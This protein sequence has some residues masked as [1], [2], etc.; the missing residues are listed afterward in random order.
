[1]SLHGGDR[2]TVGRRSRRNM[3][4]IA[5]VTTGL[6]VLGLFLL[7]ALL[8]SLGVGEVK[9]TGFD[10][11]SY[12]SGPSFVSAMGNAIGFRPTNASGP[13]PALPVTVGLHANLT[14]MWDLFCGGNVSFRCAVTSVTVNAPFVLSYSPIASNEPWV[15]SGIRG[16]GAVFEEVYVI[17][18]ATP[19]PYGLEISLAITETAPTVSS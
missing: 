11:R 10:V 15:W 8:E 7:P 18:P 13:L 6:V 14:V 5:A 2:T 12:Y 3:L 4:V 1:M 17:G 19:G 16:G 9:V